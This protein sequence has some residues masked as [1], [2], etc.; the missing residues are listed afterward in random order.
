MHEVRGAELKVGGPHPL[1]GGAENRRL[2]G[3]W[4]TVERG[5]DQPQQLTFL[6]GETIGEHGDLLRRMAPVFPTGFVYKLRDRESGELTAE[7]F[8]ALRSVRRA[9]GCVGPAG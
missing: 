8:H 1:D 2:L 7:V 4:H 5:A 6:G 9:G 3:K